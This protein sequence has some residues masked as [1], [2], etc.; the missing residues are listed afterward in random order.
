MT[1][2]EARDELAREWEVACMERERVGRRSGWM[3]V[4]GLVVGALLIPHVAGAVGSLVTIQGG[5]S[6]T[7]A[8][9]TRGNQLQTAEAPPSAF[10]E[11]LRSP[12]NTNCTPFGTV[13]ATKGFIVKS[14]TVDVTIETSAGFPL[15]AV[16]PNGTCTGLAMMTAS[17]EVPGISIFPLEP[18]FAVAHGRH[19]SVKLLTA[20]AAVD[21]FVL[22]YLVPSGDVPSTTP[23]SN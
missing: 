14:V 15:L 3:L 20:S 13:P 21:V 1:R 23:I 17:T 19:F 22:G 16:W 4:V 6:T 9:V 5:G 11:F 8:A 10:R 12:T 7:K 18:G 2:A